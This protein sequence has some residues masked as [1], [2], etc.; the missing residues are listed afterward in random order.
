MTTTISN[1]GR[2]TLPQAATEAKPAPAAPAATATTAAPAAPAAQTTFTQSAGQPAPVALQPPPGQGTVPVKDV[3]GTTAPVDPTMPLVFAG[4]SEQDRAPI[5]FESPHGTRTFTVADDRKDSVKLANGQTAH[6]TWNEQVLQVRTANGKTVTLVPKNDAHFA[7]LKK[8]FRDTFKGL[9]KEE[10]KDYGPTEYGV[11][12]VYQGHGSVG[13]LVSVEEGASYY[14]GGAHPSNSSQLRTFDTRTG[15]PVKLTQFLDP[16]QFKAVVDQIEKQLPTL[17]FMDEPGEDNDIGSESFQHAQNRAE[18]EELVAN[19]F[20]VRTENGRAVIDV[21]WESGV[22]AMGGTMV[23]FSFEAPTTAEFKKATGADALP[24]P[25]EYPQAAPETGRAI[26]AALAAR[27]A[28]V[29]RGSKGA[30]AEQVQLALL[31][32]G[33]DVG[34]VDG[35]FGSKSVE[36]LKKF[37]AARGLTPDGRVG[38]A[39][40]AALELPTPPASVRKKIIDALAGDPSTAGWREASVDDLLNLMRE[41]KVG[42][43]QALRA[44]QHT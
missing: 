26:D 43:Q 9:T 37:Q 10:L 36:A 3:F 42:A 28:P 15:Q 24:P 39:T 21:A 23:Q 40:A 32:K 17:K 1:A 19:N 22:H 33:F 27:P 44:L 16:A 8:E 6:F 35:V 2:T 38:P 18:L 31:G 12:K 25:D 11:T 29:A 30:D 5:G 7:E 20:A 14:F 41:Q 4:F 34:D 13:A